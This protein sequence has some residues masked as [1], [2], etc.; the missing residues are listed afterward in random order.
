MRGDARDAERIVKA[1]DDDRT[2]PRALDHQPLEHLDRRAA[3]PMDVV[4]E[5]DATRRSGDRPRQLIDLGFG[6]TDLD[7]EAGPRGPSLARQERGVKH[8]E[9]E[10]TG[11]VACRGEK[12]RLPAPDGA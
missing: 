1:R 8:L 10:L 5:H 11:R 3:G 7:T 4:D 6:E 12:R 2:A 9:P